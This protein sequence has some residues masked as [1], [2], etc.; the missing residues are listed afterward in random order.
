MFNF[1]NYL[2]VVATALITNS[3]FSEIWPISALAS[4]GLLGNIIFFAVSGFCL[5]V[6]KDNFIKWYLKRFLR[7]YPV[8]VVV[9]LFTIVLGY[10]HVNSLKDILYLFVYPTNYFFIVWLMILYVPFYIFSF[11]DTKHKKTIELCLIGTIIL[12]LL[13]YLLFVDKSTYSIDNVEKPF[14]M[15]LYFT[16]MLMGALFKKH[17]D[18][19]KKFKWSN[20][21][22][23]GVSTVVYFASKIA[24]S[25]FSGI[26]SLQILNQF[27]IVIVLYF[28]FATFTSL[29][30]KLAKIPNKVNGAI[31]YFGGLTLQIYLVQFV[32]IRQ[33]KS[34][35]FPLNL[36]VVVLLILVFAAL[37]HYVEYL[38]RKLIKNLS[39]VKND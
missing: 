25:R 9:T 2:R 3:H 21:I 18:K 31:K 29:E 20:V 32:I 7:V 30:T 6:V 11:L 14:I 26:A 27:I 22:L 4:G 33:F 16:S 34:L 17:F 36:A 35:V 37:T 19:F 10:Y 24:F 8:L 38:I 13:T 1:I 39:R 12:W 23:L 15:F 28:A 5:Y